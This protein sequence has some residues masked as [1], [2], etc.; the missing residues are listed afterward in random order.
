MGNR[1]QGPGFQ[2]LWWLQLGEAGT[3]VEAA[4]PLDAC[5]SIDPT[6]RVH[7]REGRMPRGATDRHG[8][9]ILAY[10]IKARAD[11]GYEIHV[12]PIETDPATGVPTIRSERA[13]VLAR[14]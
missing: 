6:A 5:E 3:S 7:S 10:L 11:P 9:L 14:R 4:G 8:G 12:A 1:S 13:R 2:E